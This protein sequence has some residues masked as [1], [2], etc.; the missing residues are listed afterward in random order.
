MSRLREALT[1]TKGAS[2]SLQ[3]VYIQSWSP[4][5]LS[6]D[7]WDQMCASLGAHIV[8]V[9]VSKK[10]FPLF[11]SLHRQQRSS[12]RRWRLVKME[13]LDSR[14]LYADIVVDL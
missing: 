6:F 7:V 14:G 2:L 10:D 5:D 12:E 3:P 1:A 4:D 9:L 11:D 13:H 8:F